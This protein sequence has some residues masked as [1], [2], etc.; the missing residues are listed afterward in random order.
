MVAG[1]NFWTCGGNY[2]GEKVSSDDEAIELMNDSPY[3]LTASIWTTS[4]S[5]DAFEYIA[6][7]LDTGTVLLNK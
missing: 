1:R 5:L 6:F 2:E 4:K 3:G 7:N